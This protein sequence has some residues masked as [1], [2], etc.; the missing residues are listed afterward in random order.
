M[1]IMIAVPML[2]TVLADFHISCLG[3]RHDGN[4]QWVHTRSSLVYDS[5]NSLARQ[6]IL[7]KF[8]RILWLDSDMKFDS[9]LIYRLSADLDEGR[10]MVSGL[11]FTRKPPF[12]PVIFDKCGYEH[13]ENSNE[14]RPVAHAYYD[15]P[16]D[17][18][19]EVEACGF[20]GV[21]MNVSLLEEVEKNYGLPFSPIMGFGEDMSFCLRVKDLGRKMYCDS[22]I[23]MGHIGYMSYTEEYYEKGQ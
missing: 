22:R 12:K 6:A 13:R 14:V 4:V 9:D 10:D 2:D 19:F 8:D 11:Y 7:K 17:D 18:V 1:K 5:R 21:M 20:G 16:K 3:L 23:K 15:Y